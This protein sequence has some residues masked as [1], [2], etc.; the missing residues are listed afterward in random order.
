MDLN[1]WG[2][3]YG[4]HKLTTLVPVIGELVTYYPKFLTTSSI[5]VLFL[6]YGLQWFVS[7]LVLLDSFEKSGAM[8][9]LKSGKKKLVVINNPEMRKKQVIEGSEEGTES[10]NYSPEE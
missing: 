3:M 4:P 9:H 7:L 2:V 10:E 8:L 6:N 1:V 5:C